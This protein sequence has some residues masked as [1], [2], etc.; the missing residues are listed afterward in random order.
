MVILQI[1]GDT[2][3]L[4]LLL[5]LKSH[6]STCPVLNGESLRAGTRESDSLHLNHRI[7]V[8]FITNSS[9]FNQFTPRANLVFS[10]LNE[11]GNSP[12]FIGL[13]RGLNEIIPG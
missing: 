13:F 10:F 8:P 12:Y 2:Q 3:H 5:S 7:V 9:T 6:C 11:D 1:Q 4:G